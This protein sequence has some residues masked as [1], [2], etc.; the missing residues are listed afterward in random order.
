MEFVGT[1]QNKNTGPHSKTTGQVP[2]L[3]MQTATTMKSYFETQ[4]GAAQVGGRP[5]WQGPVPDLL[6]GKGL[7]KAC[8]GEWWP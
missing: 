2:S 1:V 8:T 6:G 7:D 4:G 3:A 5:P